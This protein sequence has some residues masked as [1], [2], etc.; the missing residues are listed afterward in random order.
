MHI[1]DG[2]L[3]PQTSGVLLA[4][5]TPIWIKASQKV[6]KTLKAKQVPL[7]AIGAAFAFTIMMFNVPLPGGT[8]GHAV[9]GTLV[10]IVL[11]PWAAT[12]A[13]TIALVVQAIFFGDGGIL[14]IGANCFNMAFVLPFVGYYVYR[15]ISSRVKDN[16]RLQVLAAAIGSYVGI[17]V[18]ALAAAIEF[19]VQPSLFHTASGAALYA[20]YPLSIAI[21][22]MVIPHLLVAGVVEAIATAGVVAYLQRS[23]ESL[24]NAE[25]IK[26]KSNGSPELIAQ[27]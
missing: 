20:P 13:V 7:L 9:G 5:M 3:S 22:A 10:A 6:K 24:L 18:A 25:Q 27:P 17:N 21:P 1:P 14:A 26:A 16:S 4:A 11:G 8:T 15:A 23:D 2:Y 12:I 19:G